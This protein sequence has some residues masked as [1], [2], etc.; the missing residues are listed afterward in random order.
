MKTYANIP[1]GKNPENLLDLYLP[2]CEEFPIYI[3][4]HGGGLDHGT[5]GDTEI[6]ES[7]VEAKYLTDKG[8]AVAS[9]EYRKYPNAKYP[10]FIEDAAN[11]VA[12]NRK[13]LNFDKLIICQ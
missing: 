9:A 11:T 6:P 1:Y 5:K 3:H 7:F 2:D 4:F 12:Y 8:I 10:E 13:T